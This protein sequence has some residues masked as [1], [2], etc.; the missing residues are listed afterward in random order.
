MRLR[1]SKPHAL[2]LG[3]AAVAILTMA[4][5]FTPHAM[6]IGMPHAAPNAVRTTNP[7]TG[8]Y[9][10]P[11]CTWYSWQ[12]LHDTEKIDLQIYRQ[13]RRL[14]HGGETARRGMV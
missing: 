2:R 5:L 14:D 6:A 4:T 8:Q 11:N 10:S 9:A 13:R 7:Y 3:V 1:L 12:R